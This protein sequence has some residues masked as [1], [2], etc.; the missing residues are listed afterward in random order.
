[1]GGGV[2]RLIGRSEL[3]KRWRTCRLV[4]RYSPSPPFRYLTQV[5][6]SNSPCIF[7]SAIVNVVELV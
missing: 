6:G 1:M 2:Q 4:V 5:T 7:S 3:A